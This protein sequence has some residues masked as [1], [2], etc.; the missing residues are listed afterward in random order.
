M[1]V[2]DAVRGPQ[3]RVKLLERVRTALARGAQRELS[4]LKRIYQANDLSE[5][6]IHKVI[7]D[8]P[9]DSVPQEPPEGG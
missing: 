1:Q 7:P 2:I 6:D 4:R 3:A 8:R 5:A 9:R